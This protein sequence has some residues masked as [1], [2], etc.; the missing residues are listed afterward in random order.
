MAKNYRLKGL[1]AAGNFSIIKSQTNFRFITNMIILIFVLF[2]KKI[3]PKIW[4]AVD[5]DFFLKSGKTLI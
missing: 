2:L 1:Q 4:K 3:Q 5:Y